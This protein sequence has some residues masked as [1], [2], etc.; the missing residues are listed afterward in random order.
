MRCFAILLAAGTSKRFGSQNKLHVSF[1]GKPLFR[2]ILELTLEMACFEDIFLVYSDEKTAMLA[3]NDAVT[4]IFNPFPEKGLCE[5]VRLG[6]LAAE[7]A[8]FNNS[9]PVYYLFLNCDQ[10]FLNSQ[11][12]KFLL[13]KAKPGAIIEAGSGSPSLFSSLFKEDRLA[14]KPGEQHRLIKQRHPQSVITVNVSD[15]LVLADIDTPE[16]LV[17]YL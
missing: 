14:L 1:R 6:V 2:N 12:I 10:P 17:R 4:A 5:S 16:D 15:T 9:E 7:K 3:K 11:T 8:V 13:E